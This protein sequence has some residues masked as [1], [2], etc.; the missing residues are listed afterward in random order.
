MAACAASFSPPAATMPPPASAASAAA[1]LLSLPAILATSA[2]M[3]DNWSRVTPAAL[4]LRM[5][6]RVKAS[7]SSAPLLYATASTPTVAAAAPMARP[8]GEMT[9][10]M[11]LMALPM[12]P[13]LSLI[14]PPC[15]NRIKK[16]DWPP[17]S[18]VAMSVN[19]AGSW[20]MAAVAWPALMDR[21]SVLL[22][23]FS[24]AAMYCS[25]SLATPS[26]AAR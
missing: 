10:P 25:A 23:D 22:L 26:C 7:D 12:P 2:A 24:M 6:L 8:T 1:A 20:R 21:P 16:G 5:M 14:W 18:W 19:C 4:P 13:K 11:V 3:P 9:L 15:C 17:A